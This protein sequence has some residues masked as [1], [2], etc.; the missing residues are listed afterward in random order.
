MSR[1]GFATIKATSLKILM[2]L[3]ILAE[4]A[5]LKSNEDSVILVGKTRVT[6]D[7]VIAVFEQ[8]TTAEEI[9]YR[10]PSLSLADVY[11][12]IAFYLNHQP[13]V[14]AY[15]QQRR[16]QSQEIRAMNQARFDPQGLR[17]RLLARKTVQETC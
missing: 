7:T 10:Y 11:A 4:P 9:V 13:E 6:L 8:G 12:T 17:D 15:L 16:Q 1:L 5:P 3:A 14:Q 2:T